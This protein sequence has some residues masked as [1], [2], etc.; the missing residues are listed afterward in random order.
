MTKIRISYGTAIVLGLIK[1]RQDVPPTTA[2][3]LWD[4]GCIGACS[5]CPR[6]N[7]NSKT[8]KLSRIIW[9]EFDFALIL[10]KLTQKPAPFKRVC[11]QT[12]Y[13]PETESLLEK[14]ALELLKTQIILSMTLSPGQ[15]EF[16]QKMLSLGIDHI[17]IGL[18]C[19]T[20]ATYIEHKR[21]NW[22]QDWPALSQLIDLE[23]NKIEVHL[24]Y[25]LGDS[26]QEF[27]DTIDKIVKRGGKISLFAL[28]PVKSGKAPDIENYRRIQIARYLLEEGKASLSDFKFED[29]KLK[30]ISIPQFAEKLDNGTCFRT[31]GCGDCNRP[32]YNERPGQK[33]Y[34]FPRPL[35]SEEF[36]EA[37]ADSNL[38]L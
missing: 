38:N 28:T 4:N 30:E 36:K 26:E 27:I 9:P 3:L 23:K 14:L 32:Y 24:I 35:T 2:Y 22:Q 7:G 29:G 17:G 10:E 21:R 5:F 33:F 12:G 8:K 18:D 34:N 11:L 15:P 31:S 37:L 1:A 13:N 20:P 6:A 25:G 16:A 19:A